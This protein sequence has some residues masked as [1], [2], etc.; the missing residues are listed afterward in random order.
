MP[1]ATTAPTGP[2]LVQPL[3]HPISSMGDFCP[4]DDLSG[5]MGHHSKTAGLTARIELERKTRHD[6]IGSGFLEENG[7]RVASPDGRFPLVEHPSRPC[8][9]TGTKWPFRGIHDKDTGQVS[10]LSPGF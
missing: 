2:A 10:L 8:G 5:G 6:G 1:L 3:L 4:K 9:R 7:E